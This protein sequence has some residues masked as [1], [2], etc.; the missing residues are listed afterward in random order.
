MKPTGAVAWAISIGRVISDNTPQS[1]T[2]Y[3]C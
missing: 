1:C 3:D 2:E